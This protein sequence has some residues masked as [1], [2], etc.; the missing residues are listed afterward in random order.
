MAAV[1]FVDS[2]SA[3]GAGETTSSDCIELLFS[4]LCFCLASYFNRGLY[5]NLMNACTLHR[6][7]PV[8]F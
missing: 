2:D 4:V 1:V 7:I 3:V 6:D 5:F 8:T